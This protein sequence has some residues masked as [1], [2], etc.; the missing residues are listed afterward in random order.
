MFIFQRLLAA[1]YCLIGSAIPVPHE[2]YRVIAISDDAVLMSS[3]DNLDSVEVALWALDR[4]S[5]YWKATD[6]GERVKR[7]ANERMGHLE[8]VLEQA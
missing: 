1:W 8:D 7:E 5:H 2:K 4:P 3:R 6:L